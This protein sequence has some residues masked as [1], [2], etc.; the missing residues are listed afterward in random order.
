MKEY[1]VTVSFT[2]TVEA[3]D[4]GDAIQM[5]EGQFDTMSG[6]ELVSLFEYRAEQ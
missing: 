1:F 3:E 5:A 4:A 6:G 2:I